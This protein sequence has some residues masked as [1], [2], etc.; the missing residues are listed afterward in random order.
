MIVLAL[1]LAVVFVLYAAQ[2]L[3]IIFVGILAGVCIDGL[4]RLLMR[5]RLPR[6]AAVTIVAL[7]LMGIIIGAGALA[8]PPTLEQAATLAE[9]LPGALQKLVARITEGAVTLTHDEEGQASL[10]PTGE[11][12]EQEARERRD[13]REQPAREQPARERAEPAREQAERPA[14]E[15]GERTGREQPA[16]DQAEPRPRGR[17]DGDAKREESPLVRGP[18]G[19][20]GAGAGDPLSALAD[21]VVKL[22]RPIVSSVSRGLS[23]IGTIVI[24]MF[25]GLYLAASPAEYLH[26]VLTLLPPRARPRA[27][28]VLHA[29]ARG[30][31]RWMLGA[32]IAMSSAGLLT[33]VGLWLL[34]A[35]YAL[36]LG[37]LAGFAE[38]IPNVG[39]IVAAVPAMLLAL[40]SGEDGA[41]W[42]HV[43]LFYLAL[44][45]FQSYVIQPVAQKVTVEV[46][47]ALS[48][49][50]L[51]VL[52]WL[53]GA[54][55]LFS[56]V[57]LVVIA[58]VAI[59]LLYVRDVLG[60][61]PTAPP[62]G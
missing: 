47:P 57:P 27:E 35:P 46:S 55:G 32:G 36:A 4:A 40:T 2:P 62:S 41:K 38:L 26:G 56:A 33:G 30:L 39:P 43:G 19:A 6:G 49:A 8:I 22:G 51:V 58:T 45:T 42:W 21:G 14:R 17:G 54:L 34:G 11:V 50:S 28:E 20:E 5:L 25:L 15:Q 7:V 10:R 44:Q 53:W 24:I 37:L 12:K 16:R 52:G 23:A 31:R 3:L 60:P 59:K 9:R 48:I 13:P 61:T 1:T 18:G 29:T